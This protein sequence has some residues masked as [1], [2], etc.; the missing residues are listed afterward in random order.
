MLD[1]GAGMGQVQ[2]EYGI[3][4]TSNKTE[5]DILKYT[6]NWGGGAM[7]NTWVTIQFRNGITRKYK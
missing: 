6:D 3:I 4:L 7:R 1:P 5:K 2:T